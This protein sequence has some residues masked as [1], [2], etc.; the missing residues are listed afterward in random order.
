MEKE[1]VQKSS[2]H[3]NKQLPREILV[4]T[5]ARRLA[6][7]VISTILC[8]ILINLGAGWYLA[9]YS[10]NIGYVLIYAKWRLM[11]SLPLGVDVLIL[12]DSSGNQGVDPRVIREK[13]KMSSVNLCTIGDALVLNDLRMLEEYLARHGSPGAVLMVHGYDMWSRDLNISVMSKIPASWWEGEPRFNL[14]LKQRVKVYLNRYVPTYTE[15]RS[16]TQILQHPWTSFQDNLQ[17]EPDGFK[18]ESEAEPERVLE[19]TKVHLEF[20]RQN[21]QVLSEPNRKALQRIRDL[22][23]EHRF[24]VF[25]ANGPLYE[26]LCADSAFKSYYARVGKMLNDF[27]LSSGRIHYILNPP[28]AFSEEKMQLADHVTYDGA[29]DYTERLAAEMAP[30]L[31]GN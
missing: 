19:D 29:R 22:A 31:A 20:V 6:L 12:G 3:E 25:I 2:R 1:N 28:M 16:L 30:F 27:A 18:I 15:T 7:T 4:Q 8:V 11:R 21:R 17:I 9:R 13:L 23:E 26:D 14:S 5:T 24:D 10:P